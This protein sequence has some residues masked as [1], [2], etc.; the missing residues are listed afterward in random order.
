MRTFP[1]TL[2]V[3]FG[4]GWFVSAEAQTIDF[5][6]AFD[7]KAASVASGEELKKQSNL[8]VLEV[9]FRPVGMLEVE[10]TNPQ[11][12]RK[13]KKLVW[14]QVYRTVNRELESPVDKTKIQTENPQDPIP[15]PYLIPEFFLVVQGKDSL[16]VYQDVVLPEAVA[17]I[18]EREKVW[19]IEKSRKIELKNSV[20]IIQ[21]IP[22]P[23][24]ENEK[25]PQWIYGV[26]TWVDVDPETDHFAIFAEGFSNGYLPGTLDGEPVM[27]RK[28]IVMDFWRPGDF[29]NQT[30]REIRRHPESP[31]PRWIYRPSGIDDIDGIVTTSAP[32]DASNE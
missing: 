17:A 32:V 22:D 21:R 24:P 19:K 8:F 20:Q 9:E 18:A 15:D 16:K 27:Q 13:E 12:G 4:L 1:T 30:D 28:T 25:S 2:C 11:T 31:E 5:N 10:L 29:Y 14:Y 6:Q 26:A 7:A 3:L 23:I